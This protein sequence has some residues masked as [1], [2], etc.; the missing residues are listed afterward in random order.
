V[1]ERERGIESFDVF[2]LKRGMEIE[3]VMMISDD[4]D[5]DDGEKEKERKTARM[6]IGK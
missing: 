3:E 5:N 6:M 2:Q 4:D 1:R